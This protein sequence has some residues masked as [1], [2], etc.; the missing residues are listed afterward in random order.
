MAT[1]GN[2]FLNIG[3]SAKGLQ[4][5]VKSAKSSMK[6]YG[7]AS[8]RTYEHEMARLRN[9]QAATK[10]FREQQVGI[11][12]T[13]PAQQQHMKRLEGAEKSQRRRAMRAKHTEVRERMAASQAQQVKQ[14]RTDVRA[15][16]TAVA[17]VMGISL[18]AVSAVFGKVRSGAQEAK[19]GM[20]QFRFIGPQGGQVLQ[21]EIGM[22]MDRINAAADPTMSSGMLRQATAER[23][24]QKASL[25]PLG[26]VGIGQEFSIMLTDASAALS[27]FISQLTRN[28][29]FSSLRNLSPGGASLP[30]VY[31]PG[32]GY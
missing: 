25:D 13:T 26:T 22:L 27:E 7:R 28:E 30:T 15:G 4:S 8:R 19:K 10:Q 32:S 16:V 9:R 31:E 29:T 2:L 17:A 12:P 6:D 18:A 11:G 5:A 21:Q 23:R 20:E 1:V 3:G 14:K 24:L